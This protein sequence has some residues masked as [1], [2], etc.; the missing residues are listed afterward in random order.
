M[1]TQ[2]EI[3]H[4]NHHRA[5][6]FF[7]GLLIG[8]TTV[9]LIG[10]IT[11]AVL[12]YIPAI[13]YPDRCRRCSSYRSSRCRARHLR[14]RPCRGIQRR[15]PLGRRS[16]RSHRCGRIHAQLPHAARPA[17]P[18][19]HTARMGMGFSCVDTAV[20][21]CTLMLVALGDKP[22]R[23]SRTAAAYASAPAKAS[24]PPCPQ[25][26]PCLRDRVQCVRIG[27]HLVRNPH[28]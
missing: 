7:W 24:G 4:R 14:R 6:R 2:T 5:V 18:D 19:G 28:P 20:G 26:L 23:R 8:A 15:L 13:G 27:S 16:S 22:A 25:P 11:H 9:S 3:T 21:V 1:T 10:N 17:D 12:P